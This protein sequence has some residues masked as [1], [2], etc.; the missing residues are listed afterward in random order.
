VVRVEVNDFD[1]RS[2]D[3][4]DCV[5]ASR[6]LR[7]MAWS[8]PMTYQDFSLGF[9][10]VAGHRLE[11]RTYWTDISYGREDRVVVTSP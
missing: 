7:R 2:P 1:G 8:A 9:R 5:I 3:C 4:G 6:E 10:A 11:F